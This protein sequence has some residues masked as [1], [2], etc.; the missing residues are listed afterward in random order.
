MKTPPAVEPGRPTCRSVGDP[1]PHRALALDGID[2]RAILQGRD[3]VRILHRG[4]LYCLRA[5]RQG[6][7]I[8]TK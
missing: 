2:S 7:L 3:A 6:K 1:A 8:L 4:E 5:T